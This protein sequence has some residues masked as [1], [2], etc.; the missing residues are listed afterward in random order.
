V[1]LTVTKES[2][3]AFFPE[4]NTGGDTHKRQLKENSF[5]IADDAGATLN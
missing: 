2:F 5:W 4:N 1:V 3:T